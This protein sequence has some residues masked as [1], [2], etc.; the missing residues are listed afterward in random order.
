MTVLVVRTV[1]GA[2]C[3][4]RGATPHLVSLLISVRWPPTSLKTEFLTQVAASADGDDQLN[5]ARPRTVAAA[6]AFACMCNLL[7]S[8]GRAMPAPHRVPRK[9]T[10]PSKIHSPPDG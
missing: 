10:P 5:A 8:T 2:R 7:S 6:M 4:T 9:R 1:R 3:T